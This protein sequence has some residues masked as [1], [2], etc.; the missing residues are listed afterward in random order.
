MEENTTYRDL[1]V[2][3]AIQLMAPHTWVAAVAP[4]LVGATLTIGLRD[5]TPF[6]FFTTGWAGA[7]ALLIVV[8]ML[9]CAICAQSAVNTLNDYYDFKS[10]TDTA[11]NCVDE[12]DAAIIYHQLNPRS[13]KHLAL[14]LVGVAFACG[15]VVTWLSTP[16]VL[17]LGLA[18]VAAVLLYSAGPK[19]ISFLPIGELV[20]GLVMGG[21][22]TWATYLAMTGHLS[23]LAMLGAVPPLITIALIM[24]VNNTADIERDITAGRRTLPILIGARRSASMIAALSVLA[25]FF[26]LKF[27]FFTA[28]WG[29]PVILLAAFVSRKHLLLLKRGPYDAENRPAVMKA[30]VA[31]AVI[32]NAAFIVAILLGAH[33]V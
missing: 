16:L 21:F 9:V 10:G 8:L 12:T 19:P 15:L 4:V 3:A 20:S 18:G 32:T 30:V 27:V 14:A 26:C 25:L 17:L 6:D 31:Q 2:K 1:N 13:A 33:F 11:E 22:I 29:V 23:W 5:F 24:Q 28:P 7:T